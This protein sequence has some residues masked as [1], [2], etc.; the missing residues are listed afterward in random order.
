MNTP[1]AAL[2]HA[3]ITVQINH[4]TKLRETWHERF[5]VPEVH[6]K[7]IGRLTFAGQTTAVHKVPLGKGLSLDFFAKLKPSEEL[8]VTLPGAAS[9]EKNI[10]PLFARVSTFRRRVPA[11]MAFA[12]PTILLDPNREMLLSWFLG[13]PDFDPAPLILQAIRRAQGKTGAKRVIFVG[14]SGGGHPALRLSAML[15][16]SMA[17]VHEG[18]TNIARS[19][20]TSVSR[21]F[22]TVW[23]GWDQEMLL[24]AFP[25]RFD[26]VRHYRRFQPANFVYHAQSVDDARFRDDH[27]VPFRDAHGVTVDSGVNRSG[28]RHFVLYKGAIPG[29]GKV[30]A[31]E[32]DYHFSTAI[33]LWRDWQATG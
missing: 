32:F 20:P 17:Y 4:R 22:R 31:E 16:G 1:N 8:I 18:A 27:Y 2:P 13:G 9:P 33:R 3:G 7:G 5:G 29:H 25:E 21:Y 10:Y 24:R 19:L 6:Q 23:P 14:G 28:A 15:P 12:D 11:V 26:M 30:T